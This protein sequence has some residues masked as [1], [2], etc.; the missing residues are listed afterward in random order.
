MLCQT[1]MSV[2]PSTPGR[3]RKEL[4]S[5]Q[6]SSVAEAALSCHGNRAR[7]VEQQPPARAGV[8]HACVPVQGHSCFLQG[9]T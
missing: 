1:E 2:T 5:W 6:P 3:L 4:V 8:V 7:S 9:I